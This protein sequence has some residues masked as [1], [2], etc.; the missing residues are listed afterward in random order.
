[1]SD[2]CLQ[3]IQPCKCKGKG[4]QWVGNQDIRLGSRKE[5]DLWGRDLQKPFEE[6][7][8]VNS[9]WWLNAK[10]PQEISMNGYC[11]TPSW[12]SIL[13]ENNHFVYC[14]TSCNHVTLHRGKIRQKRQSTTTSF[15]SRE[16][17]TTTSFPSWA[18]TR[19]LMRRQSNK[20]PRG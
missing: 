14:N 5:W 16:R 10:S 19:E 13:R 4:H 1:M 3:G 15:S 17:A 6:F 11:N 8:T 12:C 9:I 18:N 20:M 7:K 2:C